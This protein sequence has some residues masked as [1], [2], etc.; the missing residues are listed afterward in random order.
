MRSSDCVCAESIS[1]R[2]A[3]SRPVKTWNARYIRK[4]ASRKIADLDTDRP[5]D[6]DVEKDRVVFMMLLPQ[7]SENI[8]QG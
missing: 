8:N 7:C 3:P 4:V 2:R 1:S 5:D 6:E